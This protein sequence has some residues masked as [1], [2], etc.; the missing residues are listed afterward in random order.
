M[1]HPIQTQIRNRL[2]LLS[3]VYAHNS[4]GNLPVDG[5][6]T[7]RGLQLAHVLR[8]CW[9]LPTRLDHVSAPWERW[10][11]N[12]FYSRKN[13]VEQLRWY[14]VKKIPVLE[15]AT[16]VLD[17]EPKRRCYVFWL[18][19]LCSAIAFERSRREL[20]I[21]VAELRSM[22][23]NYKNTHFLRLSFTPKTG[24][25]LFLKTGVWFLL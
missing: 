19:F 1:P 24:I 16:S 22:L 23:K 17:V 7:L 11:L 10:R 18:F 21:D 12:I 2:C 5:F 6:C 9:F 3:A 25:A 8:T 20:S 14:T 4:R 13:E 15:N